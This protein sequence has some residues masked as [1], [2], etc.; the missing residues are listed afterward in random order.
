[1]NFKLHFTRIA[2]VLPALPMFHPHSV[3]V[4][5]KNILSPKKKNKKTPEKTKTNHYLNEKS[6]WEIPFVSTNEALNI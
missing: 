3:I 4:K 2:D 6:A 5:W 1:M